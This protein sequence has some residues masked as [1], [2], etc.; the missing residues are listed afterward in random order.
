MNML[1][2]ECNN[3]LMCS[4]YTMNDDIMVTFCV[5]FYQSHRSSQCEYYRLERY[6]LLEQYTITLRMSMTLILCLV[7]MN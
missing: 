7:G 4:M 6:I 2:I 5:V 3:D 1:S